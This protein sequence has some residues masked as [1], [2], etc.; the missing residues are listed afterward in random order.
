MHDNIKYGASSSNRP[1]QESAVDVKTTLNAARQAVLELIEAFDRDKTSLPAFSGAFKE[2][3]S[4]IREFESANRV[5]VSAERER[6]ASDAAAQAAEQ[7][8]EKQR[9]AAATVRAQADGKA[10]AGQAD[11]A[12]QAEVEA[13]A[14][15]ESQIQ[16]VINSREQSIGSIAPEL[17]A[18]EPNQ[19]ESLQKTVILNRESADEARV[20]EATD[21]EIQ[22][23]SAEVT[24]MG[25]A[26]HEALQFVN[27][28]PCGCVGG[29]RIC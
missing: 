25:A 24:A 14:H 29:D 3:S 9:E 2:L 18:L 21:R 12:H 6:Q 28:A 13:L 10:Q 16:E 15:G 8:V 27:A 26:E 5:L 11:L 17:A 20:K 1:V 19:K 4:T 22:A 23:R 7:S